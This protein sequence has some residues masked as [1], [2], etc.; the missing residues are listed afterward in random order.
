MDKSFDW[1]NFNLNDAV[2]QAFEDFIDSRLQGVYSSALDVKPLKWSTLYGHY[3]SILWWITLF[4]LFIK[5]QTF[6]PFYDMYV[7]FYLLC[8]YVATYVLCIYACL[9][10]CVCV[11]YLFLHIIQ[12]VDHVWP[13][14]N[15][16]LVE[17]N[18]CFAVLMN[19]CAHILSGS[20]FLQPF[21]QP[22]PP[23]ALIHIRRVEARVII[24]WKIV[25]RIFS[26]IET[27]SFN[28]RTQAKYRVCIKI[29]HISIIS[30]V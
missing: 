22:P 30:Q 29:I 6:Y 15:N 14:S 12:W 20:S 16:V 2:K 25:I 11:H 18:N 27:R 7:T 5:Q 10:V 19:V 23:V 4:I 8:M 17:H 9:Y 24:R 1:K 13:F 3:E 21:E 26:S 28:L